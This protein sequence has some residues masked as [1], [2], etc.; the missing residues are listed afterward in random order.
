MKL[1]EDIAFHLYT[2]YKTSN[3]LIYFSSLCSHRL[4]FFKDLNL[5]ELMGE[6]WKQ[7]ESDIWKTLP[8]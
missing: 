1:I 3:F 8:D 2:C 7:P 6:D 5:K 4:E